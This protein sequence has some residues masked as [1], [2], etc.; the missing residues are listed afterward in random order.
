MERATEYYPE[1]GGAERVSDGESNEAS[2]TGD[3]I[4]VLLPMTIPSTT[5]TLQSARMVLRLA[6]LVKRI[7][8]LVLLTST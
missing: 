2:K 7:A 5:R 1:N 8:N 6:V 4:P 3:A